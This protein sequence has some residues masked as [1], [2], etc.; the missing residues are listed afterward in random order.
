MQLS[1][2]VA[3]SELFDGFP[4]SGPS[5]LK[6]PEYRNNYRSPE[7]IDETFKLAYDLLEQDAAKQYEFIE[8]NKASMSASELEQAHIE[9]EKY[10]PEVLLNSTTNLAGLDRTVPIYRKFLKEK[11]ES[12]GQ[13]ITM[14]RLEQLHIIP[15]TLPTLAPEVE[16]NIKFGHNDEKEFAD[17]VVPGTKMPAF[18]VSKPPTIEIQEF[19]PVE[20]GTGLYSVLIVNPDVPN[21]ETNGYKTVLH[22]GLTNV[23]LD[24]VNNTITPLSLLQ[25]PSRVFKSYTPLFPEKNSPTQ[26]ACLWVFRQGQELK[27]VEANEDDFDIRAFVEQHNLHAV[28]AHV[29][30]QDYDRST[31]SVREAYGL[32]KGRVFHPIRN[33]EPL[34]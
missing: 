27:N 6:I 3:R 22:Y 26:R 16:V 30:R 12:Y 24:F 19:E 14:Q 17:W 4:S 9:A 32:E 2:K 25:D 34:L 21:L 1:D 29:W 10:N 13:M 31:N 11:W 18:A 7:L 23:P 8:Q 20:N 28:G 5:S 15:D 33:A